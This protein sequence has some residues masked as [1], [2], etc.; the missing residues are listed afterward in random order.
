MKAAVISVGVLA[1]GFAVGWA[2]R[3]PATPRRR[4]V[5]IEAARGEAAG[6]VQPLVPA[7]RAARATPVTAEAPLQLTP[8]A[9]GYD[10]VRAATWLDLSN[11][12]LFER[13]PRDERWAAAME[14]ELTAVVD[15]EAR[16]TGLEA[17]LVDIVC[18]TSSCRSVIEISARDREATLLYF[19]ALA[20]L[21]TTV[22]FDVIDRTDARVTAAFTTVFGA[23]LREP[24]D[25]RAFVAEYQRRAADKI[26]VWR[27]QWLAQRGEP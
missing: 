2:L 19:Q 15:R 21:G 7:A 1:V 17:S 24:A 22:S 12:Q 20:P 23:D 3:G 14:A 18:H 4:P 27:S 10:G 11:P 8:G 16:G 5:A 26:A 6:E 9:A 13:E 25:Y